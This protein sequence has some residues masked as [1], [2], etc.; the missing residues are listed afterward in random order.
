MSKPRA[1]PVDEA[2]YQQEFA[3]GDEV[4]ALDWYNGKDTG[5]PMQKWEPGKIIGVDPMNRRIQ[6]HFVRWSL[7]NVVWLEPSEWRVRLAPRDS[8]S[9]GAKAVP[10]ARVPRDLTKPSRSSSSAVAASNFW[11]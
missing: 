10:R 7:R 4:D 6:V 1:P 8:R 3:V 2:W 11:R 5:K 9:K